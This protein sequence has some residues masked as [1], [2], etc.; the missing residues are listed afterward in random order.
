[1][2]PGTRCFQYQWV[3]TANLWVQTLFLMTS[4]QYYC[5]P[6]LAGTRWNKN[7]CAKDAGCA[8]NKITASSSTLNFVSEQI[9]QTHTC[10]PEPSL[11]TSV[12]STKLIWGSA[13]VDFMLG[14][15]LCSRKEHT[16]RIRM[17]EVP[18]VSHAAW[19]YC[20]TGKSF[21]MLKRERRVGGV[22]RMRI[23]HI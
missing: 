5:I 7:L 21:K 2:G 16:H 10:F 20:R 14:S 9:V 6:G 3:P 23:T 18:S 8:G 4:L 22:S 1:M 17:I 11:I 12:I 19:T 13:Q 15:E